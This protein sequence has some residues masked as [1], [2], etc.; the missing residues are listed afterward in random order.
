MALGINCELLFRLLVRMVHLVSAMLLLTIL[1]LECFFG[2]DKHVALYE[3][4]NFKRTLNGAGGAMIASGILLTTLMSKSDALPA[5]NK[6]LTFFPPKFF[7]SLL[8][9][10]ISD[11]LALIM[12]GSRRSVLGSDEAPTTQSMF[13]MSTDWRETIKMFRLGVIVMLYVYS[14]W[15]RKF[16]EDNNNFVDTQGLARMLDR[17]IRKSPQMASS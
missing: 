5:Q 10:P 1:I 2:L 16:R 14:A 7:M 15:V 12:V 17:F 6:W 13:E 3:D 8:L 4:A 11:K 9:T